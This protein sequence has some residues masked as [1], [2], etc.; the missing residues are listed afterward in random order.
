MCLSNADLL[1][2]AASVECIWQHAQIHTPDKF[3][4]VADAYAKH[5]HTLIRVELTSLP[6]TI[7]NLPHHLP[8]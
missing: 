5:H 7:A 4:C 8:S 6:V 1:S 2:F 3:S